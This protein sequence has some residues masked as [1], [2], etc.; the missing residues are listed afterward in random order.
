M[1]ARIII[2]EQPG[3]LSNLIKIGQLLMSFNWNKAKYNH[4][5]VL[6]ED[7]GLVV[8]NDGGVNI[9]P[10]DQYPW[11]WK[12]TLFVSDVSESRIVVDAYSDIQLKNVKYNWWFNLVCI[13]FFGNILRRFIK[14]HN[15]V[16]YAVSLC[17]LEK[18]YETYP[19]FRF[20][21]RFQ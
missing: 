21:P 1:S 5:A 10:L 3:L 11:K 8:E 18:R 13:P 6:L 14:P 15:C 16:S 19:P 7:A 17:N 9:F 4:V 2:V 12:H 20:K